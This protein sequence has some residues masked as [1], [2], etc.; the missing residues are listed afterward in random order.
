[1]LKLLMGSLA[2]LFSFTASAQTP[3]PHCNASGV[4][5]FRVSG[6]SNFANLSSIQ[7][8]CD[9]ETML[10]PYPAL[11][12]LLDQ[13]NAVIRKTTALLEIDPEQ[14]FPEGVRLMIRRDGMGVIDDF[15]IGDSVILTRFADWRGDSF[16]PSI[17]AHELGH[18]ISL[19]ASFNDE[20]PMKDFRDLPIFQEGFSDLVAQVSTGAT[21]EPTSDFP[22][23]IFRQAIRD[24]NKHYSYQASQA[25]YQ[26]VAIFKNLSRACRATPNLNPNVRQACSFFDSELKDAEAYSSIAAVNTPFSADAC[27]YSLCDPHAL[28]LPWTSS[29]VQL[30]GTHALD[31]LKLLIHGSH[32]LSEHSFQCSY[33]STEGKAHPLSIVAVT[34]EDA[35]AEIES[36]FDPATRA[37]WEQLASGSALNSASDLGLKWQKEK[38]LPLKAQALMKTRYQSNDVFY[39]SNNV[40]S[41]SLG[42]SKNVPAEC[43]IV[44]E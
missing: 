30:G 13:A 6:F 37:T 36:G 38:I 43:V 12:T 21:T 34:W 14:F 42:S 33:A 8:L 7:N 22:Q 16:D 29:L 17:F 11:E 1:M 24:L 28:S 25:T 9:D 10:K 18:V 41:A 4:T 20:S 31:A 15:S 3:N 26:P 35:F 40:C 5:H 32:A 44:C 19:I 39:N 2:F 27:F 23:S